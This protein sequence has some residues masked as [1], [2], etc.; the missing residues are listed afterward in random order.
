[1]EWF[2]VLTITFSTTLGGGLQ[3]AS[4]PLYLKMPSQK[5]CEQVAAAQDDYEATCWAKPVS[6]QGEAK[7]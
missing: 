6:P 4:E 1:M 2:L 7:E 3:T 5:V